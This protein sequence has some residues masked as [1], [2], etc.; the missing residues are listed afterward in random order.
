MADQADILV[1]LP[2]LGDRPEKLVRALKS[3]DAQRPDV[4]VRVV[5]V[6]PEDKKDVIAQAKAHQVDIVADPGTGM[7]AAINAGLATRRGEQFYI[8]LGDDD[9][10]Q[11]GGL[12][13]LRDML[14][15]DDHAVVAYGACDY[16]DDGGDVLWTSKAGRL[17]SVLI[18][19]GPNLVPHPAAMMRLDALEQVGGYDETLSLVMDLDVLLK[20]KKRGR[21]AHTTQVVSAF[22]WHPDSLTVND[23]KKSGREARM[24]KRRHLPAPLRILEPLWEYPVGWASLLAAHTLNRKRN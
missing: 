19:K 8:W 16:V 22:G 13:T 4:S 11:P 20:L 5:V 3:V 12:A 1:V 2:T 23:R 7:S 14:L 21:F 17:A 9:Y 6:I 24:V 18:G 10:Y 15:A